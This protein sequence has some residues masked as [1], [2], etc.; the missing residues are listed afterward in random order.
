MPY[1][2][3]NGLILP[4]S[5]RPPAEPEQ[6]FA[7]NRR[8]STPLNVERQTYYQRVHPDASGSLK[9]TQIDAKKLTNKPVKQ[10]M[11]ILSKAAASM[12]DAVSIWMQ[13][14]N[15]GHKWETESSRDERIL[16]NMEGRVTKGSTSFQTIVGKFTYG[17]VVEGAVCGEITGNKVEGITQ[18]DPVSPFEIT[19]VQDD[20]AKRGVVDI[21]GQGVG[22]NFR[23]L[24][25][26]RKP[27]PY[28]VYDPVQADSI[29]N[30]GSIPFLPGVSSE[31]MHASLFTKT[32]QYLDGQIFPKGF[33]SF[34]I[35]QLTR[36]GLQ[37]PTIEKW[38]NESVT[39]LQSEL[40]STDPSRSV[41]S[42]VPTLW[43]VVGTVG[44][45]N[46]DGLEMLDRMISRNL[47]RAYKLPG[48]LFD[49][50]ETGALAST[51]E[52]TEMLV[53]LRRV[54]SMQGMHNAAFTQW[55]NIELAI[56]G[57]KNEC[58]FVLDDTDLEGERIIAEK[59][60]AV[61]DARKAQAE[62]D[63]ANIRNGIISRE[64]AR[65]TLVSKDTRYENLDPDAVPDM[66]EPQPMPEPTGGFAHQVQSRYCVPAGLAACGH[67]HSYMDFAAKIIPDGSD[68]PLAALP[69]EIELTSENFEQAAALWNENLDDTYEDLLLAQVTDVQQSDVLDAADSDWEWSLA[70]ESFETEGTTLTKEQ[71]IELRDLFTD[72]VKPIIAQISDGLEDGRKSVQQ[73]LLEMRNAV[74]DVHLAQFLFGKGG[75]NTVIQEDID[76]VN[77]RVKDQWLYLQDFARA[78]VAGSLSIRQI[79]ARA[80]NYGESSTRNFSEGR[81]R[82]YNLVLP[83]Y[84]ADGT[85]ECL[86][87]CR[88]HWRLEKVDD[89][90][91]NAF[92]TLDPLAQHCPTCLRYAATYDPYVAKVGG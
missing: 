17:Q 27:N 89:E 41:I 24:Q 61:A 26:P 48:F 60:K 84:P 82:A 10:V 54:R 79:R 44:K 72:V 25:D 59:D 18:I 64:E 32:D 16:K 50:G 19:F 65:I 7:E 69:N 76:R 1:E 45:V 52:R 67:D 22:G 57:S 40:N 55:G 21:I 88:C 15:S 91:Y 83:N 28:F 80:A 68:Q 75:I 6:E 86:I 42:K 35:A 33:F 85:T 49:T 38:V 92:W 37:A 87:R 56:H 78:I 70:D 5:Y 77:E 14:I 30:W 74:R 31:I 8:I 34:D 13:Y 20:D 36:A 11:R 63:E 51:K 39:E 47:K 46:L 4:D 71:Q 53:W 66:P 43:S 12:T 2:T 73:W 62:A 3:D 9:M 81:A 29:E 90:T 58:Q 23:V